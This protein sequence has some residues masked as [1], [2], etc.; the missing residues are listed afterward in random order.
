MRI[1]C[2]TTF[3]DGTSRYEA[4]DI[5]TVPDALGHKFIGLGWAAVVGQPATA[6]AGGDVT[7]DINDA[8]IGMKDSNHG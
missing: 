1:E 6:P 5:R 3:L 8:A 4:G 7:L 2:T